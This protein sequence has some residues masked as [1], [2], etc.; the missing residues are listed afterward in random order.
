MIIKYYRLYCTSCGEEYKNE[1]FDSIEDVIAYYPKDWVRKRVE[2]G[3]EWDF[4]PK[5]VEYYKEKENESK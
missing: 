4:C 5:C 2:N 1:V 3:S